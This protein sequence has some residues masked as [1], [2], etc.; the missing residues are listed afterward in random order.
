MDLSGLWRAA[1]A[2]EDLRRSFVGDGFDDDAWEP[3]EVP[4]HWRHCPAFADSDGP[5]LYRRTFDAPTPEA[6]RRAWLVFDGVFYQSDVWL[7]EAYLGETEGYFLPRSF[8]VTR[9]LGERGSHALSVEVACS[10]QHDGASK[11]NLTGAFQHWPDLDPEWNPGGI[12]R[13]VRLE[14][15]GPVR[16]AGLGAICTDADDERATVRFTATVDCVEAQSITL[17]TA[18]DAIHHDVDHALAAGENQVEWEVRVPE[19]RLWWPRALGDQ[20][21]YDATVELRTSDGRPS[22]R[23]SLRIG[24]RRVELRNWVASVNGERLFLKGSNLG[25]SRPGLADATGEELAG[26]VQLAVDAGLDLLRVH[27]HVARPETYEAADEAG[28]LLWQDL[29]LQWGYARGV[30]RE[31]VRQAQGAVR[32]LGHHP[33]VAV[34]CGHDEPFAV[35][36]PPGLAEDERALRRTRAKVLVLGQVPTWNRTVLDHSLRRALHRAD[37]SRPVLAH[38]GVLPSLPRLDGTDSHLSLGWYTGDERDL[39][40]L[41]RLV[42]RQVRFVSNFGAQAVP[43]TADFCEPSRWPDLDW[44][45]LV[46]HHCLQKALLDRRV[47]PGAHQSFEGWRDATQ[48]YQ[49]QLVKHHVET[50]RR[51]KYRP[52]GG[53]AHGSLVDPAPAITWSVL[54]HERRPKLGYDALREAC[55]PV[56]VVA[57]R[58][59]P[60]LVAG[61]RLHLDI[62]AVSDLRVDHDPLV[63]AADLKWV[64]G[65]RR[66]SWE[67]ELPADSVVKV[68]EL[69]WE[70]PDEPGEVVLQL[71]L[72]GP[73]VEATNRYETRIGTR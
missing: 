73:D 64:G 72:A 14:E 46:A 22:D 49:A 16:I 15:T 11:R 13:P 48:R 9:Q 34:W 17:H 18:L 8:E 35:D 47:R 28:M 62:H 33:S 68:G 44:E 36:T 52:C 41:A 2:D 29:P 32:L 69:S 21:L 30:R 70:V 63:V 1:V 59:P 65:S 38:S 19:P 4:G 50:L 67:G 23:R 27:A 55:R 40:R 7:D 57:D 12:W 31:A 58:P 20:P 60:V 39:A 24:L 51:L 26:D 10:P 6:G 43:D 42:P 66:W 45:R 54:D 61:D 5:L 37:G 56:I 53:F 3:L 25:P 71:D